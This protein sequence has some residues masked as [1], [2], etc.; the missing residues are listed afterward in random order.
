MIC[1]DQSRGVLAL[2]LQSYKLGSRAPAAARSVYHS[3]VAESSYLSPN[4]IH[5]QGLVRTSQHH[6]EMGRQTHLRGLKL[7]ML[8]AHASSLDLYALLINQ[9]S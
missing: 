4:W 9:E 6:P 5:S 8:S 3:M 7:G 1:P 2:L